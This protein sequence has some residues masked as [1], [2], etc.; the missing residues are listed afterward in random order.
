MD[1]VVIEEKNESYY[2]GWNRTGRNDFGPRLPTGWARSSGF[3]P[4][5][6]P[7]CLESCGVGCIPRMLI[8]PELDHIFICSSR[9]GKDVR[10][11]AEA[12]FSLGL[13]RIHDGQGTANA[14]FFF[15]NAYLELLWV[16]DE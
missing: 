8:D 13:N 16:N 14:L 4:R 9:H 15:D 12:G 1:A 11:L 5:S 7:C 10:A 6:R 2:C 3:E